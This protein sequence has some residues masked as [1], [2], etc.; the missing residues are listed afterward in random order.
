G[1]MVW[2]HHRNSVRAY[3]KQQEGYGRAEALLERKWPEKYNVAGHLT[4]AGRLYGNGLTIPLWRVSRIYQGI[5]GMAP[6]QRLTEREP[7]L[8][9]VLPL[10]PEWYLVTATFALLSVLGLS[11][12][13]LLVAVPLVLWSIATPVV[14]AIVSASRARFVRREE[15]TLRS[16]A[17]FA[18][19]AF[20]H[21]MQPAAR[22]RGRLRHGLTLWRQRGTGG[23]TLPVPKRFPLLVT[24][25]QAPEER[26]KALQ[27][28]MRN[29]G[30]V[31][32]HGGDYDAWDLEVRGGI[33]GSA[34]MLMATE[35]TGSGTQLVR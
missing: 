20:L 17:M 2:H 33:C 4:W 35:D 22:L 12:R 28:A 31:V 30:A 25:W 9:G 10:M 15:S 11:W 23:M 1:A 19:V 8:V 26:L 34:R 14:Q 24:R 6:F 32:L 16:A 29:I 13:P 7:G 3:W 18:T 5:W 27:A 21:L